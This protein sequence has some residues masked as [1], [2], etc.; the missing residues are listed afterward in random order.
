[1]ALLA[2]LGL[3]FAPAAPEKPFHAS[4]DTEFDSVIVGP[5]AHISVVGEGQALHMGKTTA[6]TTNQMV[7]LITGQ[8]SATYELTAANGDTVVLEL[9]AATIFLPNGVTFA[10]SYVVTGG[11]GRFAGAG[12]VGA[13]EGSATFTGPSNGFGTFSLDGTLTTPGH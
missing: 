13:I 8:A 3:G 9:D 5:I 12:G 2:A 1:V 4:F 11:T 6:V 7:N 10:G